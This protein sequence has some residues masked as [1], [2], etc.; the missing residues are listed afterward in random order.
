MQLKNWITLKSL[1]KSTTR[2][3]ELLDNLSLIKYIKF[4]QSRES[5]HSYE[6]NEWK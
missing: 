1:I 3:F 2:L 4:T 6:I 5:T